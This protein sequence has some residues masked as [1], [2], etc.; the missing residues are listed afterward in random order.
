MN[1]WTGVRWKERNREEE[2]EENSDGWR[3]KW[4]ETWREKDNVEDL[5]NTT[6][7]LLARFSLPAQNCR[8][9]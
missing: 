6:T 2:L 9:L 8:M 3:Q 1:G 4:Q 5:P 7:P